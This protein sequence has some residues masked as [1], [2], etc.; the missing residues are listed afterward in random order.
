MKNLVIFGVLGLVVAVG[1]V[2]IKTVFDRTAKDKNE[3]EKITGI[4]VLAYIEK[5]EGEKDVKK[6]RIRGGK[7]DGK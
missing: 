7:K 2:F 5:Q 4:D 1:A 6:K 3:L